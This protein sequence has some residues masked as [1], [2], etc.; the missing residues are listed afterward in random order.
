MTAET[1]HDARGEA[2]ELAELSATDVKLAYQAA[3][4]RGQEDRAKEIAAEYVG[5]TVVKKVEKLT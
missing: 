1:E 4:E 2:K 5:L 3:K